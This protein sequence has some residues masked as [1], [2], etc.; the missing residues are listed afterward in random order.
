MYS[1]LMIYV[2]IIAIHR[3]DNILITHWQDTVMILL[4]CMYGIIY[5]AIHTDD[6]TACLWFILQLLQYQYTELLLYYDLY[7]DYC[8]TQNYYSIYLV[9]YV[10]K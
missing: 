4:V 8:N 10:V 9:S 2:V 1:V 7:S 6:K 5:G 3:T